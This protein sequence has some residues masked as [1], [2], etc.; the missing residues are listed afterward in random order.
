MYWQDLTLANLEE[1]KA[2]AENLFSQ[3]RERNQKKAN[4]TIKRH[5]TKYKLRVYIPGEI[6]LVDVGKK[7]KVSKKRDM[8]KAIVIEALTNNYYTIEYAAGP[9]VGEQDDIN[10]DLVEPLQKKNQVMNDTVPVLQ[11][12]PNKGRKSN[13]APKKAAVASPKPKS[14]SDLQ[15]PEKKRSESHWFKQKDNLLTM[16][17]GNR[18]ARARIHT[19]PQGWQSQLS[20]EYVI[21]NLVRKK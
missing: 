15:H 12:R 6:V 11:E 7:T 14:K 16:E 18:G 2:F 4:A 5:E 19:K 10:G 3:T 21:T 8:V 9:K 17:R 20:A 1:M 13:S